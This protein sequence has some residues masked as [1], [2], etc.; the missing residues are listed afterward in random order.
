MKFEYSVL[1]T[2]PRRVEDAIFAAAAARIGQPGPYWNFRRRRGALRL[3]LAA[4]LALAILISYYA[5][6]AHEEIPRSQL[7]AAWEWNGFESEYAS[8]DNG[9]RVLGGELGRGMLK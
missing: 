1:N 8:L 5:G 6:R 2:P 7:L 4:G 9:C 3:G